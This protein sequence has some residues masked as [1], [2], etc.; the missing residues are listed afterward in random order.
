MSIDRLDFEAVTEADLEDLV[1]A[2]V[3]EGLTMEYKREFYGKRD[4]DKKEALKDITS[5]ANSHGGHLIIGISETGGVPKE[6]VPLQE[7]DAD[8]SIARLEALVRDGIEPRIIG[9]RIRAINVRD[10]TVLVLRI[11]RSWRPPHRVSSAG[12]NRF[13]L[14]NSA[15]VYEASVEELRV[16]FDLSAN[17]HE[18]IKQF[19][20]ERITSILQEARPGPL[21]GNGRLFVHLAPL[22]SFGRPTSIDPREAYKEYEQFRPIASMGMTPGYNLDGFINIPGGEGA[23]YTQIFRDGTLEAARGNILGKLGDLK[24]LHGDVI[25]NWIADVLPGYFDGLRKLD[26]SPPIVLMISFSHIGEARLAIEGD[27]EY[28]LRRRR[29]FPRTMPILLPEVVIDDYD[30]EENYMRNLRRTFDALW[31][32]A[33]FP[34]CKYFTPEGN[35]TRPSA[36]A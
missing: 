32:A 2:G 23:G 9:L 1:Q 8:A 35:W 17:T 25:T 33:G 14:R 22:S 19:R 34:S 24:I 26:V 11:P 13:Y 7:I 15:G 30:S 36:S 6:L 28:T 5:F 21:P 3:S 31:N 12:T 10:G 29:Y 16:L 4:A 27:T 20:S 18:R